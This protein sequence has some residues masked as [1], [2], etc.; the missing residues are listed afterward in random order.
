MNTST[1]RALSGLAL[2]LVALGAGPLSLLACGDTAGAPADAGAPDAAPSATA[3]TTTSSTGSS[4]ADASPPDGAPP[5]DAAPPPAP[6][7]AESSQPL[8]GALN[9][10]GLVWGADGH[11]Y[12]SGA[13]LVA[14]DRQ[15]AVWRIDKTTNR[16]DPTFGTNGVVTVAIPGDETSYD[17]LALKDGS[18]VVHAVSGGKVWLAKLTKDAGGVYSFGAPR[19]LVFGW[20]D[21]D[22]PNWPVAGATPAYGSWGLALDSSGAAE[23]IVVFASGPPAVVAAGV[24][25][26]DADR[27]VARLLASDLSNDPAFNG[28]KPTSADVDGK[29]LADN[30]RRGM[31]EPDGTILSAG[32]TD[33]GAGTGVSVALLRL[34]ADGTPD[35]TFGFGTTSPGQTKF[36]PFQASGGSAEAYGVIK[37]SGGRYVT[38]GYGASNLDTPTLENDLVSFGLLRDNLDPSY[39]KLGALAVQS[40]KD[41][42]AGKGARKFRDNGRDLVV[43]ADDR[44]VQVGCYDDFASV[45]VFTKNGALDA[46]FGAGGKLQ[47]THAAPFYKVAISPDKKRIAATAATVNDAALLVTL[48]V[49]N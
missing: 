13:T 32:Y 43:L 7:A 39:G 4:T 49:G 45:F 21:A 35:A 31:V 36:N 25:R 38:T 14:G 18:F 40:E 37:Q 24:Q 26:T 16:P 28:G 29:A 1:S 3:T 23:K 15:L 46:T 48:K 44:T 17:L 10:Y 33:F 6:I 5:P 12:V 2:A 42:A 41:P 20:E 11:L 9:P 47:S 34:K 27:W 8:T 19:A 22:F 30:A